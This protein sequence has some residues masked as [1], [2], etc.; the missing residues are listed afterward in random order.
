MQRL[1]RLSLM[2]VLLAIVAGSAAFAALPNVSLSGRVAPNEVRVLL[3]DSTYTVNKEFVIG[4]TLIIE[5]GT[6]VYFSPNSKI[7]DSVGGRIIADGNAAM[8]Y[9]RTSP[10]NVAGA[11]FDARYADLRY[12]LGGVTT[13]GTLN[14]P[15][16]HAA[17]ANIMYNVVLDT[18]IIDN[19]LP[20]DKKYKYQNKRRLL[21]NLIIGQE[22]V[23]GVSGKVIIPFESALIFMA[24]RL[25]SDPEKDI[26]LIINEWSRYQMAN[27][28]VV[29]A[30]INFV[31]A[32]VDNMSREWGHIVILP[33]SRAAFFRNCSF[34]NFNKDLT[35]DRFI[36]Y[37]EQDPN[38]AAWAAN[39][40]T[41]LINKLNGSGGALS[42]FSSRTWLINCQFNHNKARLRGGA[43]QFLQAPAGF[44]QNV[45]VATNYATNKNPNLTNYDGSISGVVQAN[46]IS[47]TDLI[48]ESAASPEPLSD[49]DRQY[50]DDSRLAVYLGR[51]RNL[52]FTDNK[53]QHADVILSNQG[54]VWIVKDTTYAA[55]P[56][57]FGNVAYGGAV[58][59]EGRN[60]MEIAFGLNNQMTI[61]GNA[62][63]FL[64][65]DSYIATT[66]RAINLQNNT[67]TSGAKGGAIYCGANTSLLIAGILDFNYTQ[68]YAAYES[69]NKGDQ[70]GNYSKGGAI[71]ME[72]TVSRLQVRG[73][74]TRDAISNA[75][76]FLNNKAGS[77]G[78]IYVDGNTYPRISPYI[79]GSDTSIATRDYGFNIR[80]ENN[81]AT[82]F[83]GAIYT[84]R[85]M[86][87]NGAGGVVSNDL[88]GYGL[89][90]ATKYTNNTAGFAGGAIY[91]NIPNKS[92]IPLYLGSTHIIRGYF[93][94]NSVGNGIDATLQKDIRGG[95]AIYA[96]NADLSILKGTDFLT[97]TVY[98]G[99]GAAVS[100]INSGVPTKKFFITD[101]D[102]VNFD[103]TVGSPTWNMPLSYISNNKCFTFDTTGDWQGKNYP[104]DQRMMN[105]FLDNKA[106]V[107]AANIATLMGSGT[108]QVQSG[109]AENTNKLNA[110]YF[111]TP[112]TGFAVGENGT[113]INFTSGGTTWAY[114]NWTAQVSLKDIRFITPTIGFIAG[115]NGLLLKTADA[116]LTWTAVTVPTTVNLNAMYFF[117]QNLGFIVGATG[118][119]L[120]TTDAGST[121]AVS[122]ISQ[123]NLNSVNF[124]NGLNGCVVGDY[125]QIFWTTDGGINWSPQQA[126]TTANL[127]SVYCTD[128]IT[129]YIVGE[130]GLILKTTTGGNVWSSIRNDNNTTY[131]EVQFTS[132]TNG[133]VCGNSGEVLTTTDAGTSWTSNKN[134]TGTT[135]NLNGVVIT[136]N[137]SIGY[138]VGDNGFFAKTT[139]AAGTWTSLTPVDQRV[140]DVKRKNKDTQMPENGIGL[141]GAL[142][143]LNVIPSNYKTAVVDTI[144]FN[145]ARIQNNSAFSGP[146]VYSD[147]YDSKLIF[148]RS[149]I[150][151]N[152][153]DAQNTFGFNQNA[154]TG[155]LLR[156]GGTTYNS[157]SS[158]LAG[159]VIYGEI[160]GPLPASIGS[161]AANSIYNNTGRFLIRLPDAYNSKGV[162][163][164]T[165]GIGMGGTDTLRSNYWGHTEANVNMKI[166]NIKDSLWQKNYLEMETF[167]VDTDPNSNPLPFLFMPAVS[168]TIHQ[169]P[170]E[171]IGAYNSGVGHYQYSP[172]PLR[173]D[174]NDDS[175]A[176]T[177][178]FL[179]KYLFSGRVYDVFDKGTDIKT[180]DYSK[181]R[182]M[183]IEDFAVGIAPLVKRFNN[184]AFPSNGKYIKRWIRDPFV[185]EATVNNSPKYPWIAALQDEFKA[186]SK[187]M[188]YH[189]VGYPLFLE[190]GVDYSGLIERSNHDPR[191]LN[192]SIFFVVN[193]STGDYIRTSLKQVSEVAPY[194]EVFRGR[195]DLVPDSSNRLSNTS[196]R[197]TSEGLGNPGVGFSLLTYLAQRKDYQGNSILGKNEDLGTLLGRKYHAPTNMFAKVP[198]LF[199]NRNQQGQPEM[200][201]SNK[202]TGTDYAT[203]FAGERYGALPVN[204]GDTI[205]IVSRTI[206]WREGVIPAYND[207][208]KFVVRASTEPPIF[209]GNLVHLQNDTIIKIVASDNPN[210]TKDTLKMVEYLNTV[211]VTEDRSYPQPKGTYSSMAIVDGQGRDSIFAVTA[212]DSNKFNDPRY[213]ILPSGYTKATYTWDVDAG[214]GLSYWLQA[215]TI[216][217][218]YTKDWNG[219][220]FKVGENPKD[221]ALGYI[222]LRGQPINPFVVPGGEVVKLTAANY[223][224]QARTLDSIY[225]H[226]RR[227]NQQ[228]PWDTVSKFINLFGPYFNSSVYDPTNAR[229]MQQDTINP[230]TIYKTATPAQIKIFVVDSLPRFI[231]FDE[232]QTTLQRRMDWAG[233]MKD[234]VVY[235]PTVYTCGK[236][237]DGRLKANLTNKLRFQLDINTDDEAEDLW[238]QQQG[239]VFRYGRTAYGY[240]NT[241]LRNG[242]NK[243]VSDTVIIDP[244]SP[245]MITQIRPIWMRDTYHYLF[246]KEDAA[247]LDSKYL[248]DFM[249]NGKINIRIDSVAA[250]SLIKPPASTRVNAA[251][252]TD[253]MFTVVINDGH[254][255]K[256]QKN[257]PV[258]I[259]VQPQILTTSLP[260][261]K[262]DYDYNTQLLDSS[263]MIKIYDP[264]FGQKH[265]YRLIYAGT[266]ENSIPVDP[267][268]P[269]AGSFDLTNLKTT[270]NWLKIDVESGLL[271]GTPRIKDAPKSV[272]VTILVTDEDSLSTIK[273]LDLTVDSTNHL[274]A[275]LETPTITCVKKGTKE[276]LSD[277]IKVYELDWT[278]DTK[279]QTL[280]LRVIQPAGF[281]CK[282]A[283]LDP[284]NSPINTFQLHAAN[285]DIITDPDGRG[286]ITVEVDDGEFKRTFVVPVKISDATI[287]DANITVTNNEGANQILNFGEGLG[288]TTGDGLDNEEIGFLDQNFCEFQIPPTPPLDVF[289]ARWSIPNTGGTL[290]NIFPPHRSTKGQRVFRANF[291]PGGV[292]GG[293][294]G[295]YPITLKWLKSTIPAKSKTDSASYWLQDEQFGAIFNVN[296][297]TGSSN[298]QVFIHVDNAGDTCKVTITDK[299]TG[300]I[301]VDD[302]MSP[303]KE[304]GISEA[305]IYSVT[306]TPISG[307]TVKVEFGMPESGLVRIDIVD[308]IGNIV[309]V[310]ADGLNYTDGMNT[311]YWDAKDSQNID[312]VSGTYMVRMVTKG[313][314]TTYPIVIVK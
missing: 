256:I 122:T 106:I 304:S 274:P 184:P 15:T 187:G 236:T 190:S 63:T 206:L 221:N 8:T 162:L 40:N 135:N 85:A 42:T 3:K 47:A 21:Q 93:E 245:D 303:V 99:N 183:P 216:M 113:I 39:M 45:V 240:M 16:V 284:S 170:F 62:V 131:N 5:P 197:R 78:A 130:Y 13:K 257:F 310:L 151:G 230:G 299:L 232:P 289:D 32:P 52:T 280:K 129:G 267:C 18:S 252:N 121:W 120:K 172:V 146:V 24:S 7:I 169:G 171:S 160:Q 214:S 17:K 123:Y 6:T 101:L 150:T 175:K 294:I 4:G 60:I 250:W 173:N 58:Y 191:L 10:D 302:W 153:V 286:H 61:G 114:K 210:R 68:A 276:W 83:G 128:A 149:L 178:S 156:N 249:T 102:Y 288:A 260:N 2:A 23:P 209:T 177:N 296:M 168:D 49:F 211:F 152:A 148:N 54:G 73:G 28:N 204:A 295:L 90:Y 155:A 75:T 139:D 268:Y 271:Y 107:D 291:Q 1:F 272:K 213:L 301:I 163:A 30:K 72:N 80:F 143:V 95:G 140:V 96:C 77:G 195:V 220:N 64:T 292:D 53:V 273:V 314:S 70:I 125:G 248:T 84:A 234:Y 100:L 309:K 198:T 246:G 254:G 127:R 233:T 182:M 88:L 98:N 227:L 46:P 164:G 14:E 166:E 147:N 55:Y 261:A 31:G 25:Q 134:I 109:T 279:P 247:S 176:G 305:K 188:Y 290:I 269:E 51:V 283:Q 26:N 104:P 264:N 238:A 87:S 33:G 219:K 9:S 154:I 97:N 126:N 226:F 201:A 203:Y 142:Y 179:E 202:Y 141:G 222:V 207:G 12:F 192:E 228:I 144:L 186:D 306:P 189:P 205:R 312:L 158:D 74:P 115:A 259:N 69:P 79:G 281:D 94:S 48:D 263:K 266:T 218:G 181:R 278:R 27:P 215:D 20:D 19:T 300:F 185:A 66:N 282:P 103:Y 161:E 91:I 293:G 313:V 43:V 208:I 200:P 258:F 116:G 37:N 262:E 212:I 193:E 76:E 297:R 36:Y 81:V 65:P 86:A 265:Y 298:Q 132:L 308:A 112:T 110:V 138:V 50:Y 277:P 133:I 34:Q 165:T 92:T 285:F 56:Q 217:A 237:R 241:S 67:L 270:P 136:N 225:A 167:F 137:T 244:T 57:T 174:L 82:S 59:I 117:Q 194:R 157:A 111:L 275:I 89:K 44:P 251:L 239:W 180:A 196:I 108:T 224:P 145:R 255:G 118:K 253:T 11:P 124:A 41:S 243:N 159:A 38:I 242:E 307:N 71:F 22:P 287:F 231:D 223:P 105:R 311:I 35:Q 119:V 29:S 199:S 235:N 229:F